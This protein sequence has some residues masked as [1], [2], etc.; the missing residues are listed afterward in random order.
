MLLRILKNNTASG[1]LF[2]LVV[3][4]MAWLPQIFMD[5]WQVM[6]F[7]NH[8]MPLFKLITD[9]LPAGSQKSKLLALGIVL[10]IG[11]YLTSFNSRYVILKDR[12]LFP[13]FFFIII[14]SSIPSLQRLHPALLSMIFFI[15]ALE[16]LLSSYK[17][18]RLSYNYFE[19]SFFIGAGSL[20]YFNFI[21]FIILVWV[22]LLILRPVI[23]REWVF[24]IMGV[25]APWFFFAVAYFLLND[26]LLPVVDLFVM[27]FTSADSG[28]FI[29]IPEVFFFSFLLLLIIIASKYV[30]NSMP[31]MKILTRKIFVLFF[32][33]WLLTVVMYSVIE[34]ANIELIIPATIPVSFLLSHFILSLKSKFWGNFVLWA[35]VAGM[36]VL[37]WLPVR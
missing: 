27:N 4:V 11:M 2:M 29:F 36:L 21:Y 1:Y 3:A 18:E 30:V 6:F 19:A 33:V 17:T 5:R 24:S 12:T 7:D 31:T 20:L 25:M 28:N 32:W 22:A 34:T 9:N 8:P 26:S 13:A 37:V 35:I 16:K 23:W 14:V 10:L 15:P